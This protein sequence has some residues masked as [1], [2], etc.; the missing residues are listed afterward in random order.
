MTGI[1]WG[2]LDTTIPQKLGMLNNGTN[3]IQQQNALL[4]LQ[5][6]RDTNQLNRLK[7]GQAQGE[8]D[9][10][11]NLARIMAESGGDINKAVPQLMQT[12]GGFKRGIELQKSV[13]DGKK[14]TADAQIAE[15]DRQKKLLDISMQIMG[16]AQDE[17]GWQNARQKMGMLGQSIGVDLLK[18]APTQ[19][20][21]NYVRQQINMGLE[22]KTKIDQ[23]FKE[24]EFGYRQ[25][26]DAAN[27]EVTMRG[28]DVTSKG[29]D[30]ADT[31]AR[32]STALK[33]T[34]RPLPPKAIDDLSKASAQYE[35][36]SRL[37]NTF[38]G[39]YG[40][41]PILGETRNLAGRTFGD[42][43]GQAQW[44]QDYQDQKNLI[45]NQLFGSALTVTERNEFDKAQISPGMSPKEIE[46][47]LA[48]QQ[49]AAER[50]LQKLSNV[51]RKGGYNAEQLDE[52]TGSLTAKPIAPTA[53]PLPDAK[54]AP[55]GNWYVQRNG[56]YL[57]VD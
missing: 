19:F 44:W 1:N 37:V 53:A 14:S 45:R 33:N 32:E 16:S 31:R 40:G 17:Q 54:R 51:Y 5:G 2:I 50:A 36:V 11:N 34:S 18:D 27:R 9:T 49:S 23:Q 3:Q 56:K 41:Q 20:D 28:Q 4:Q 12:P 42:D 39:E 13:N 29:Q 48:R 30:L 8:I 25:Q 22:A 43:S 57:R 35:N 46:K 10:E 6:Q 52:L 21:P 24:R 47:N 7:L 55:D 26:N 38:K 15:L